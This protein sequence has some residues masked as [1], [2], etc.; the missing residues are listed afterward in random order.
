LTDDNLFQVVAALCNACVNVWG[1]VSSWWVV[2]N[3]GRCLER[4][5]TS[6]HQ[7]LCHATAVVSSQSLHYMNSCRNV[8]IP[9]SQSG[10]GTRFVVRSGT[11]MYRT[12]SSLTTTVRPKPIHGVGTESKVRT[13]NRSPPVRRFLTQRNDVTAPG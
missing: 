10:L 1:A 4:V 6:R 8:R 2:G 9:R 3:C 11:E 12:L 13:C 5:F 7:A